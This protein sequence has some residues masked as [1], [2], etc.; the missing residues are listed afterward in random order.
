MPSRALSSHPFVLGPSG[1]ETDMYL[2]LDHLQRVRKIEQK[3]NS[4]ELS[5]R[6]VV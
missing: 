6:R 2:V 4:F 1:N 3:L 5:N